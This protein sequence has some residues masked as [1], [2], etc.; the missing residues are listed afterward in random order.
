MSASGTP[1][2]LCHKVSFRA[3]PVTDIDRSAHFAD[4]PPRWGRQLHFQD[5]GVAGLYHLLEFTVVDFQE[6]SV[7][8]SF[9]SHIDREDTATLSECLD[10]QN[11]RHHRVPWEMPGEIP[12]IKGDVLDAYDLGVG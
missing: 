2:D 11:S 6:I 12:L 7:V 8:S 4:A 9:T 5:H 10:L 3:N 1:D